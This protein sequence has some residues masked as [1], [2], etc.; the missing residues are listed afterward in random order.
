MS[1]RNAYASTLKRLDKALAGAGNEG[2]IVDDAKK[3]LEK[4][5]WILGHLVAAAHICN[6]V[7]PKRAINFKE[8]Y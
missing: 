7:Y 2:L 4:K 1:N 8:K 3:F 6:S 5:P